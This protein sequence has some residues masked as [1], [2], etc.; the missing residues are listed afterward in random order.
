MTTGDLSGQFGQVV[1]NGSGNGTAKV[2]PLTERETWNPTMAFVSVSTNTKE[3]V[4]AIFVGHDASAPY[5]VDA[6]YAGSS[7]DSTGRV[8]GKVL[9]QGNF[10]WAVWTGGDVGATATLTVNGTREI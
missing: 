4:C 2:G 1:L 8:A 5:Q 10:I 9:R 3:A 6:S 7:G